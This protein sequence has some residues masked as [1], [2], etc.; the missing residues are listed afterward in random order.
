MLLFFSER[1]D[2]EQPDRIIM[3]SLVF[4]PSFSLLRLFLLLQNKC[5]PVLSKIAMFQDVI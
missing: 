1:F 3:G 5:H 4:I 2:C